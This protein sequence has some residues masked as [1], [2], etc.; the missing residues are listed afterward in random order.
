MKNRDYVLLLVSY[1]LNVGVFIGI[2]TLL[3]ETVLHYFPVSCA[4]RS[5]CMII[6]FIKL[7]VKYIQI[8]A[9]KVLYNI[10]KY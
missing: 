6:V 3:N 1:G 8:L 2:S 4:L 5:H 10:N 7:N 9:L